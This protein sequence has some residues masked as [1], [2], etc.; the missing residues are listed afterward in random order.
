VTGAEG[1]FFSEIRYTFRPDSYVVE[2]EG[3][4]PALDRS[5]LFVDLGPGLAINELREVEDV[6]AMAFVGNHAEDGARTRPLSRIDEPE[7]MQGPLLWAAVKS[8]YFVQV[9]LAGDGTG[10][11]QYLTAMWAEPLLAEGRARVHAASPIGDDGGGGAQVERVGAAGRLG[12]AEGLEPQFARGDLRGESTSRRKK[13]ANPALK[14]PSSA[15]HLGRSWP[16]RPS[17]KSHRHRVFL[18]DRP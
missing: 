6:R 5:A 10:G 8:K 18:R 7:V 13:A 12:H 4:L 1:S 9:I 2:V 14:T 15:S 11:G 17:C 16:V 3:E